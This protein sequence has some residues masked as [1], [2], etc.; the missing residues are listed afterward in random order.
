MPQTARSETVGSLLRP[1]ALMKAREDARDGKIS[2][3]ALHAAE[4][5]AILDAIKL[6]KDVGLD[7]ITDGEFRRAGWNPS[8][9]SGPDAPFSGYSQV[10]DYRPAYF[11]FWRDNKGNPRNMTT[12]PPGSVIAEPAC[13]SSATSPPRSTA[14]SPG[15]PRYRTKYTFTAPSYHRHFWTEKHSSGAYPTLDEYLDRRARRICHE[16]IDKARRH[17]LRLHPARRTELRPGLHRGAGPQ[18]P[19]SRGPRPQGRRHR[20]RRARQLVF[21]GLTGVT[22]AIHVCRGN[23]G[24]GYW[25]ASGGYE[26]FAAQMF[27]RLSNIDALLLEYDTERAGGFEPLAHAAAPHHR[28]PRPAHHEGRNARNDAAVEARV[29]EAAKY[30]PLERL[31]SRPQCGFASSGAGNPSRSKSSAPSSSS[32]QT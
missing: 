15:T 10:T 2:A 5:A 16:V 7:V 17:G 13:A 21:D 27:P 8:T 20:R 14:S 23:G 1:P 11:G 6:Q 29:R 19:R 22:R 26:H 28:R 31:A 32:S 9:S 24:G 12:F 25:S 30:L 4:D 18:L 3:A